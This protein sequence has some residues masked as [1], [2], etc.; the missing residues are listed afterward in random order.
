MQNGLRI[1]SPPR[2]PTANE[3][4]TRQDQELFNNALRLY[5]NQ[6]SNGVQS[7]AGV[8]GGRYVD[9]PNGLFFNTADQT[10]AVIN[11]AYPVVYNQT[12]LNNAVA[13]QS[14]S[15]SRIEVSVGGIYNFQYSGQVLSSSGSA[16]ELAIWI[17]R[18]GTDIGYSTR[19]FTDSDNNHR[20]TTSW[21]FNIDLQAGQYIEIIAAVTS[22]D[23]WLDA[24]AAASPVPAV[25]SSVMTVNYISPLPDTL[26][27]PP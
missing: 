26:P 16:K 12:Y 8:N 5:F 10:F 15:T 25:P 2:L 24:A 13:L 6:M 21:N 17:R 19:V 4:Y 27:T 20:N 7:I 9:C 18:D 14:G 22:T 23:L 1:P 11:T 3:V